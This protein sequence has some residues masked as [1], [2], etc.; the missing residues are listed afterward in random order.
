MAKKMSERFNDWRASQLQRITDKR[1]QIMANQKTNLPQLEQQ[2][3]QMREKIEGHFNDQLSQHKMAPQVIPPPDEQ[4]A[5]QLLGMLKQQDVQEALK[6]G[7]QNSGVAARPPS[8]TELEKQLRELAEKTGVPK[9]DINRIF[10]GDNPVKPTVTTEQPAQEPLD[11]GNSGAC[12][13]RF[14]MPAI[15]TLRVEVYEPFI[16]VNG[17]KQ[18]R[19]GDTW[20]KN[21]EWGDMYPWFSFGRSGAGNAVRVQVNELSEILVV[22]VNGDSVYFKPKF[23]AKGEATDPGFAPITVGHEAVLGV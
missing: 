7:M 22:F 5:S 11:Y 10:L 6:Q 9:E 18:L 14:D 20:P 4:A 17:D 13:I 16:E 12:E 3:E 23:F 2:L 8:L 19:L 15:A 21:D 1:D